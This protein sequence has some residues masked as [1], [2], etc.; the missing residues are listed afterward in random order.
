VGDGRQG[1]PGGVGGEPPGGQ[2]GQGSVDE[3][4]VDLFNDGV[5]A[6]LGFGMNGLS[7]NTAWYR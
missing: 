4:G 5:A 1:Q 3:V 6:V 2:V 7:V